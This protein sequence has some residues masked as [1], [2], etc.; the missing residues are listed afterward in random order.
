MPV[1]DETLGTILTLLKQLETT[2]LGLKQLRG[3]IGNDTG[4][5]MLEMLIEEAEA[6]ITEVKHKL[7]Q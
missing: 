4:H 3:I 2:L 6:K 7:I 5:Q 1:T